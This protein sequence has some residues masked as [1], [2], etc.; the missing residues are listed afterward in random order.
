MTEEI[1]FSQDIKRFLNYFFIH[2]SRFT[3]H[4]GFKGA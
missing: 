2:S 3:I 1:H 4:V